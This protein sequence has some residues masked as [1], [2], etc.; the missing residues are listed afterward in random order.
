MVK[1]RLGAVN[2][3]DEVMAV[4]YYELDLAS[5]DDRFTLQE[6]LH[7]EFAYVYMYVCVCVLFVGVDA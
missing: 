7:C 6:L 1:R 4:G 5:P 3:F 2:I